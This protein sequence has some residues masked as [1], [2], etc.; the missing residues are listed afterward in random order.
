MTIAGT[1]FLVMLGAFVYVG[2]YAGFWAVIYAWDW[3]TWLIMVFVAMVAWI[4]RNEFGRG[5]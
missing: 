5:G 1:I 2:Y 4:S 3:Q